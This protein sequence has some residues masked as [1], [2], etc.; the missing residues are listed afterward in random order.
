MENKDVL[1][2]ENIRGEW[3]S[4]GGDGQKGG[5]TRHKMVKC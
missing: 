4:E 2:M 1:W 3:G 5:M